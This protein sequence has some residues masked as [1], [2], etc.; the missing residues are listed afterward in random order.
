[1]NRWGSVVLLFLRGVGGKKEKTVSENCGQRG[2]KGTWGPEGAK[3]RNAVEVNDF[4]GSDGSISA[5]HGR[6]HS[7]TF[8]RDS[9][10]RRG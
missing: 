5:A 6:G 4:G 9:A 7:V 3:E 1:M 8:W 10:Q 2:G